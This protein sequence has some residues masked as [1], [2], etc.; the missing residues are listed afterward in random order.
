LT[1]ALCRLTFALCR[2]TFALCR[3]TFAL[4]Q[5]SF[6]KKQTR[7]EDNKKRKVGVSRPFAFLFR[8]FRVLL[9]LSP[10]NQSNYNRIARFLNRTTRHNRSVNRQTEPEFLTIKPLRLA[11]IPSRSNLTGS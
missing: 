5:L 2:L 6:L 9:S 8:V 7:K 10:N 1:F 3:L 4:C 11:E